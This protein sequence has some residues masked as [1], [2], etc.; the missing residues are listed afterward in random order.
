MMNIAHV[1]LL[2]ALALFTACSQELGAIVD[3]PAAV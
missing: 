1:I 2:S 3:A